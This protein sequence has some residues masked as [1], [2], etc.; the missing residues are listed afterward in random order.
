MIRKFES[1]DLERVMQ[2]W[3]EGNL[4]A[5]DFVPADYWTSNAPMVREL[6]EQAKLHV[7]ELDGKIQGFVGM[8]G[9]YLAGLFV[10]NAH[11]SMG[12][13][14]QLL[15]HI[16]KSRPAFSLSVYQRNRR[17]VSFY[18]REGLSVIAEG[19][20]EETGEADWIMAWTKST[21]PRQHTAV[22]L[23]ALC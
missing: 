5:H 9:C 11:R 8:Q 12:I 16:K 4:D 21:T 15:E 23:E 22:S 6:L 13:G 20:D 18:L 17:A 3:L 14:K 10:D 7:Y 19:V 1:R 2:L